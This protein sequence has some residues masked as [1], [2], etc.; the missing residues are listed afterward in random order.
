MIGIIAHFAATCLQPVCFPFSIAMIFRIHI[1]MLGAVVL[2]EL[3][4]AAPAKE[5]RVSDKTVSGSQPLSEEKDDLKTA[6][7]SYPDRYSDWGRGYSSGYGAAGY[8]SLDDRYAGNGEY[9]NSYGYGGFDGD[10]Q[11]YGSG[12]YSSGTAGYGG[13]RGGYGGT[14]GYSGNGGYGG[15]SA[16]AGYGGYSA[17]AGYGGYSANAGY[18]GY[19]GYSGNGGLNSYYG[20]NNPYYQS[21]NNH[22]G[23]G[24][25][26]RPGYGNIY[27]SGIT[28]SLVTGYRGYS[29]K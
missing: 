13:Y 1:L 22:L 20:Y 19:G 11:R 10:N 4:Y 21:G 7:S 29:R 16:N 5:V 14:S 15:Y 26:R 23:Y 25:Y 8:G 6:A 28:P 2:L 24:Y 9:D 17:N 12:G 18:G 3:T 27:N